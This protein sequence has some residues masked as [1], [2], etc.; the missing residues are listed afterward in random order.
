MALGESVAPGI[1]PDIEDGRELRIRVAF[2]QADLAQEIVELPGMLAADGLRHVVPQRV[3]SSSVARLVLGDGDLAG[4]HLVHVFQQV[5]IEA[6]QH[7]LDAVVL[8]H[9]S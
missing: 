6:D 3:R 7:G 9:V 5:V 8:R 1:R 2:D 4:Q